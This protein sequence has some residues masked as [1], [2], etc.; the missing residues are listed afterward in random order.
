MDRDSDNYRAEQLLKVLGAQATGLGTSAR[1]AAVVRRVLRERGIPLAGVR[2]ADG[3]GLSSLDRITPGALAA[4]LAHAWQDPVLRTTFVD[5]LALA[6][7]DGTLRHRFLASPA[8][9]VVRA[10]TGTTDLA[11]ALSGFVRGRYAFVVIEN[12][13]P[14]SYWAAH[15]AQDRFVELLAAQ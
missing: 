12:G 13:S 1:G 4:I 3:S 5:A 11:S 15:E 14:V 8:R 7:R 10:K 9:G 6:G 2:L